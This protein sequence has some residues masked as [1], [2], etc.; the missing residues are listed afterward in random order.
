MHSDR[1]S[2]YFSTLKSQSRIQKR[3]SILH[4]FFRSCENSSNICNLRFACRVLQIPGCILSAILGLLAD[5]IFIPLI[6]LYKAPI[7]L[8]KGWQRLVEDLVGREGPF[9]E[10]VCVPFA[11]LL[12]MLWPVAVLLATIGGVLSSIGFGVYASVI[13]YQVPSFP[14]FQQNGFE[15]NGRLRRASNFFFENPLQKMRA[16]LE[17]K[18]SYPFS[19][20]FLWLLASFLSLL[21][22]RYSFFVVVQFRF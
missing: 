16:L 13:A 2:C 21:L 4:L 5:V 19:V 1:G 11:G 7:L 12:I 20:P 10:T 14:F 15:E 17:I 6:T 8:F 22:Q 9:L 3:I 18:A